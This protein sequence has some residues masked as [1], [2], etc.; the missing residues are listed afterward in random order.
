MLGLRPRLRAR[1]SLFDLVAKNHLDHFPKQKLLL[2]LENQVE[3]LPPLPT[4]PLP[5]ANLG[6]PPQYTASVEDIAENIMAPVS[7]PRSSKK[8]E[9]YKG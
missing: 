7:S 9:L 3:N 6:H 2:E 1:N 8:G 5:T 4:T